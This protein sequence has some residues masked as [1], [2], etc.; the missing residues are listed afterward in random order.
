MKQIFIIILH[1]V[2]VLSNRNYIFPRKPLFPGT[3]VVRQSGAHGQGTVRGPKP[4]VGVFL[5]H[6]GWAPWNL[7]APGH[8]PPCPPACY[9]PVCW[10]QYR[11]VTRSTPRLARK[12]VF[13]TNFQSIGY[14]GS[15]ICYLKCRMCKHFL[16]V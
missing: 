12:Y 5:V 14:Q 7:G 2:H 16:I 10:N 6:F 13:C 15:T 1:I 8:C 9:S 4:M 11:C 3:G